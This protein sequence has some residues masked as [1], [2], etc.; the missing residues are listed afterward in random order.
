MLSILPIKSL[1]LLPEQYLTIA[2][3]EGLKEYFPLEFDIDLNG[4]ALPWEA[5]T[6]IPFVDEQTFIKAEASSVSALAIAE[7]DSIRNTITFSYKKFIYDAN[8]KKDKKPLYSSLRKLES[9]EYNCVKQYMLEEY[10][11]V[12]K[13][14]FLP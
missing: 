8:L 4:R 9:L 2:L 10:K 14:S 12:G 6:L 5:A 13:Y 11:D 3:S 7:E 1:K